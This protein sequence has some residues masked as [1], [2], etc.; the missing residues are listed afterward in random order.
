MTLSK[1]ISEIECDRAS[2]PDRNVL[3]G[4][5]LTLSAALI[6]FACL[7]SVA[8]GARFVSAADVRFTV[9]AQDESVFLFETE[10]MSGRLRT[11]GP[12]HGVSQLTDKR[13]G[14][15]VIDERYSALNL[16]KLM[17]VN[18]SMGQPRKMESTVTARDSHVEI[19]WPKSEGHAGSVRAQFEISGPNSI[20]LTVSTRVTNSYRGYEL[21]LSNYFD[22]RLQPHVFLRPR[23]PKAP[24]EIVLPRFSGVFK[25]TVLVFARDFHAMRPCTD[26]RWQRS[27]RGPVVQMVPA[28]PYAKCLAIL[29]DPDTDLG[30]VLTADPR[31]CYAISTRYYSEKPEERLTD[32]S[33]FDMSLFGDDFSPGEGRSVRVRL[34]LTQLDEAMTEPFRIHE[35]FVSETAT[36]ESKP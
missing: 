18:Q 15:Q 7:L 34:A 9:D 30:I 23:H 31:D 32:Y 26:G 27:E 8:G 24:S 36:S 16:F 17:S 3:R 19:T 12:Y 22:G 5:R 10:A 21:F 20:D 14:R 13:T 2:V 33:A 11:K 28:R 29:K 6:T 35:Q 1:T 4:G 25:G